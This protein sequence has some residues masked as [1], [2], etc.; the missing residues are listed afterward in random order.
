MSVYRA[1]NAVQA[2]LAKTGLA[3]DSRNTQQGYSF[4]G[5]DAVYNAVSPLLAEHGLCILPRVLARE[6]VERQSNKGSALFYVTL[7]VEFDFV[8]SEDGSRHT[9]KTFGEAMDSADKATN[10]AMSAAYK[11]AVIQAFGI[12]TEGDNDADA[13]THEVVPMHPPRRHV[14][15]PH[16][17]HK[18]DDKPPPMPDSVLADWLAA[19]SAASDINEL[20]ALNDDAVKSANAS[21]DEAAYKAIRAA[22]KARAKDLGLA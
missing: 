15:I 1:I 16:V 21:K 18:D 6:C 4:R 2:A 13:H 17:T 19:I 14:Q 3:K 9:I 11:Y 20:R 8:C 22:V 12:P 10:K 7:E 5:I